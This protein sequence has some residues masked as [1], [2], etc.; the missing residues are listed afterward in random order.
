MKHKILAL[1]KALVEY[2]ECAYNDGDKHSTDKLL[3]DI[4]WCCND[5]QEECNKIIE[6][7]CE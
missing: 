2:E 3:N 7:M 1:R 6:T 5:L 4:I